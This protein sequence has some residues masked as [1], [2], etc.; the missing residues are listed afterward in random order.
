MVAEEINNSVNSDGVS[1]VNVSTIVLPFFSFNPSTC[2][3]YQDNALL[4]Y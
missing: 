3:L 2:D 4:Y 1:R